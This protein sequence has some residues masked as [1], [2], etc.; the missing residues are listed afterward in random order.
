MYAD[1]LLLMCESI[2]NLRE[3]FLQWKEAVE[4]KELKVNQS[5]SRWFKRLST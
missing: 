4:S 1:N 5:N 2:E 3:K